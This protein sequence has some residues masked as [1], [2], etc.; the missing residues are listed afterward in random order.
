MTEEQL[1]KK[2]NEITEVIPGNHPI[3]ADSDKETS[4]M[5]KYILWTFGR[6]YYI[7]FIPL[8]IDHAQINTHFV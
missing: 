4:I 1:K 7:Y 5:C 3:V 6:K 8:D 2:A